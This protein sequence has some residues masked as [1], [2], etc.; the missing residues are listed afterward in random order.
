MSSP[1]IKVAIVED[2]ARFRESLAI[3][4]GGAAGFAC[5]GAYPNA[6]TAL[7]EIP[8]HW[9]DVVLMDIN[10]PQMSG[11]Q[12]VARLKTLRPSLQIIMV[13]VYVDNKKN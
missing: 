2:D 8:R 11:I 6:E 9:P 4:I 7:R 13:T 10:L 12:C 1:R 5:V 3:M